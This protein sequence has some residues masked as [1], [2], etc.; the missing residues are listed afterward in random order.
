MCS[1]VQIL[2]RGQIHNHIKVPKQFGVF[3]ASKMTDPYR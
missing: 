1:N 3:D 2:H